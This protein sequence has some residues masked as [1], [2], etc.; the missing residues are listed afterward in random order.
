MYVRVVAVGLCMLAAV[1]GCSTKE[2]GGSGH[3]DVPATPAAAEEKINGENMT[4]AELCKM[5]PPKFVADLFKITIASTKP[6]DRNQ[7]P[8]TIATC[9]HEAADE[10]FPVAVSVEV[11]I[12]PGSE[13]ARDRVEKKFTG[14]AVGEYEDVDGLGD[15]AGFG[16]WRDV[17]DFYVLEV[18]TE[19]DDAH[20]DI[21]V[22]VRSQEPPTLR[23]VRPIAE[24]VL[25]ALDG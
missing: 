6:D 10:L 24:R 4:G 23:Q 3:R 14:E 1:L 9:E 2:G 19:Y 13:D 17:P 18:V 16:P 20:R 12:W 15:A 11:S 25:E 8:V 5:V 22:S 21:A 7:E